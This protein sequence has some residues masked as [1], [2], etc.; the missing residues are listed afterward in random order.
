VTNP[1]VLP[2]YAEQVTTSLRNAGFR[3]FICTIPDGERYKNLETVEDL[4]QQL[5]AGGMDRSGTVLALGGG[6]T[7]DIAGFAAATFMRGVRLVQVPTTI[8][9]MTD[10]SVGGKTGVDLPQGKN[11]VGAFKQPKTV[12]IDLDVISTL[13]IEDIRSGMAE[14]IKHGVI[15]AS[16]LLLSLSLGYSKVEPVLSIENLARSIQVKINVVERDPFEKGRRAVLNFGHTTGH[17]LEQ[18]SA[19]TLRHGEA[20]SIGMVAASRIAEKLNIAKGGLTQTIE[21]TMKTWGLPSVCPDFE[22]DDIIDAMTR[23]K[24][25][26]GNRLRWVLPR[27]VGNVDIFDDVP[28]DVVKATL[29]AMGAKQT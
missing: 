6:V 7:G 25:K 27:D 26:I 28:I 9:A 13:S 17:A 23:D 20:V 18:L 22:V 4:Y 8:L 3:S 12:F 24:K 19:Y 29:V 21:N 10:S 2:L 1:V 16:E 15:G 14:V 11:L 5:L